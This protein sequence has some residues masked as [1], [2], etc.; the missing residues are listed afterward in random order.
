MR[1]KAISLF[2]ANLCLELNENVV[3]INAVITIPTLFRLSG[4]PKGNHIQ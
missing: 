1:R 3:Y 4:S 2:I